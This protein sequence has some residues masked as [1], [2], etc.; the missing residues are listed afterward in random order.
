MKAPGTKTL[1]VALALLPIVLAGCA[2]AND[3][4]PTPKAKVQ[5]ISHEPPPLEPG[6]SLATFQDEG[7]AIGLPPGWV[8]FDLSQGDLDTILAS[9]SQANPNLADAMS[10][11][12]AAMMAQGIKLYAVDK[13]SIAAGFATNLNVDKEPATDVT[14]LDQLAKQAIDQIKTQLNI[15]QNIKFF[16]NRADI[17]SGQ[18]ERVMYNLSLNMPDGSPV[19]LA[20]TQYIAV[21]NGSAYILTYTTT[22]AQSAQYLSTFDKSAKTLTF[23]RN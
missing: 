22:D 6:W 4:S 11:Q 21:D 16:K 13:N 12:V 14:D 3:G 5:L 19:A 1:L 23:L 18:A 2:G 15:T 17:N 20:F 9:M 8:Q 7:F 10:G